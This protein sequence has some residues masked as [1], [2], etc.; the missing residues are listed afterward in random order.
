MKKKK[1]CVRIYHPAYYTIL[2]CCEECHYHSID[3]ATVIGLNPN[4]EYFCREDTIYGRRIKNI[5][6]IP[7]WCPLRKKEN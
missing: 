4:I 1:D 3:N 5:N 7:R 2:T 6:K